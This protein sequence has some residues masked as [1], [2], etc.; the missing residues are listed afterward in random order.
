MRILSFKFWIVFVV[1]LFL[2]GCK[3]ENKFFE[4]I[5]KVKLI[6]YPSRTSW[7]RNKH[8]P[9]DYSSKKEVIVQKDKIID[10]VILKKS[11]LNSILTILNTD[12]TE[13]CSI[14]ACYEPRHMFQF[15]K[16]N[17]VVAYFEVCLECGGYNKTKNLDFMPGFCIEKGEEL[18]KIFKKLGLKNYGEGSPILKE[19]ERY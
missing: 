15:Y 18:K 14:A 10:D 13:H 9:F 17:K 2:F 12:N 8:E 7:K 1:S 16:N 11:D 6:S 3:K 4:S 19:L 5:D